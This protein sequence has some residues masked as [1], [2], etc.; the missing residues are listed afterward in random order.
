MAGQNSI[1]V[2]TEVTDYTKQ[3][4]LNLAF[5]ISLLLYFWKHLAVIRIYT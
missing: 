5:F 3:N 1:I 2:L 4:C